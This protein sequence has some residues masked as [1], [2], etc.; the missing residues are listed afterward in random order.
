MA[1]AGPRTARLRPR[2]VTDGRVFFFHD[3]ALEETDNWPSSDPVRPSGSKTRLPQV[4]PRAHDGQRLVR[5]TRSAHN[6]QG[7]GSS[8]HRRA[9]ESTTIGERRRAWRSP[10]A[11]PF[12][13]VCAAVML[14]AAACVARLSKSCA[15]FSAACQNQAPEV[16]RRRVRQSI[17]P[18][19]ASLNQLLPSLRRRCSS[20]LRRFVCRYCWWSPP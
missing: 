19:D 7:P 9:A 3:L 8:L 12:F 1:T 2:P 16:V 5:R 11:A 18:D 14:T 20:S 10:A 6:K 17:N 13:L 4:V 15:E